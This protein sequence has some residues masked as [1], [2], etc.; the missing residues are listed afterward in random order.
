MRKQPNETPG[1]KP[2]APSVNVRQGRKPR[3]PR[4]DEPVA[5]M[6]VGNMRSL[7]VR[8]LFLRSRD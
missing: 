1:K 3:R 8:W 5:P 2:A 4:R 6:T 7:G